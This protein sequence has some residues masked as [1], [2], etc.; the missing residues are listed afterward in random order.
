MSPIYLPK[1]PRDRP[2]GPARK[3]MAAWTS[4]ATTLGDPSLPL[5]IL[6]VIAASVVATW[7]F[8]APAEIGLGILFIGGLTAFLETKMRNDHRDR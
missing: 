7:V 2:G 8:D 4:F 5:I 6:G 3:A 1:D